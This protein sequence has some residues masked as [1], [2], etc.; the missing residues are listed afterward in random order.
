MKQNA[1]NEAIDAFLKANDPS[2][3]H[4]VITLAHQNYDPEILIKFLT[5]ARQTIKDKRIDSELI[6]AY[7]K[8]GEEKY[9]ADLESL[10]ENPNQANLIEC[11]DRCFDDKLYLAAEII[12]KKLK[13]NP[14]LAQTYVMIK[15]FQLAFQTAQKA[16]TPKV[17]KFVC[18]AC[19]RA[20]EFNMA[21]LCGQKIIVMSDHLDELC[22]F[23]EKF[24]YSDRLIA[25]LESGL[26]LE[27]KNKTV[28]TEL[29]AKYAKY[30]PE[31][32]MDFCRA[33]HSHITIPRLIRVCEQY[34]LW[35]EAVFLHG[36]F[37]QQDQAILTMIDHSP[38]A[39][40][41]DVFC[42]NIVNVANHDLYYKAILF[43]MEEEPMLLTDILKLLSNKV[44]LTQTVQIV[45]RTGNIALI[46]QFLENVQQQ[47]ISAVNEALNEIYL[48]N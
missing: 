16:D 43:Y 10:I 18:F 11:G 36:V 41:H 14:K 12:F 34:M 38:T 2:E 37:D 28:Y 1:L 23:Y 5:M 13:N 27:K 15:K 9:L 44:D 6:F 30:R 42:Q 4:S 17:W 32:L 35:N 8:G 47:N 25:L 19:I 24:G 46:Q 40:R 45:K 3:F 22:Q 31:K 29:G 33:F 7:A 48:E 20:K 26:N 21:S 39:W